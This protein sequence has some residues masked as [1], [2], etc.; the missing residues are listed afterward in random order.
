LSV[1]SLRRMGVLPLAAAGLFALLLSALPG[2][3]AIATYGPDPAAGV[4]DGSAPTYSLKVGSGPGVASL[5]MG[6]AEGALP[7]AQSSA[8]SGARI[9]RIWILPPLP[10]PT[11][12]SNVIAFDPSFTQQTAAQ[13]A[14]DAVLDLVIESEARRAHDTKL[15]ELAATGDAL[16]EFVDV[17]NQ[18]VAA[19]KIVQKTYHFDSIGITLWLP[20]FGTQ[21]PRLIGV[22]L[23]GTAT[24]T[25][26]DGAGNVISQTSSAYAK[27]WGLTTSSDVAYQVM[28]FD[29]TLQGL[30][31]AP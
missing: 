14:H 27:T 16:G 8:A 30:A 3:A 31:P 25:T 29:F 19:G 18:D 17:I 23:T 28:Q 4:I 26:R 13:M 12:A 24:L 15:A 10:T 5:L 6:N 20:K 21:A 22:T 2:S 1:A 9:Q 7:P 11:I